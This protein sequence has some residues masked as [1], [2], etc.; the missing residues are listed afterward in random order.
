MGGFDML[1]DTLYRKFSYYLYVV[2]YYMVFSSP[3][4]AFEEA[5]IW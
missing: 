5:L 1:H 2:L 4:S 3:M